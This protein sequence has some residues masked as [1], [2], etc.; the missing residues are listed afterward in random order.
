MRLCALSLVLH[1]GHVRFG[2]VKFQTTKDSGTGCS[3]GPSAYATAISEISDR[4][5][6][7]KSRRCSASDT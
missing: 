4:Q 3:L 7:V 2:S 6:M 1:R 5:R